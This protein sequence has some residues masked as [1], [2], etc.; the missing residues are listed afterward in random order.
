[1]TLLVVGLLTL[2]LAPYGVLCLTLACKCTDQTSVFF[3]QFSVPDTSENFRI[4]GRGMKGRAST[5]NAQILRRILWE[6]EREAGEFT[7]SHCSGE[8]VSLGFI[9][10]VDMQHALAEQ[11]WAAECKP[12][13]LFVPPCSVGNVTYGGCFYTALFL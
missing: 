12:R 13:I 1:M 11:T 7:E 2:C 10:V 6:R 9:W 4:F 3:S 8:E 5:E